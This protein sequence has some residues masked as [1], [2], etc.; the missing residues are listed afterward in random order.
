[1][2]RFLERIGTLDALRREPLDLP[3][4]D[5][6]G[7]V[8]HVRPGALALLRYGHV[9]P[10][11][12]LRIA[13]VARR[14]GREIEEDDYTRTFA[15]VLRAYGQREVEIDRFWDVFIRPALN[16]RSAEAVAHYGIFTVQEAL[17]SDEPGASDLLLPTRPLG[18]I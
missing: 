14:L 8:S 12:R 16:L 3:V 7:R 10:A 9:S 5:E 11:G 1:Y 2:R 6:R 18:E 15:D 17:L 4:I 13:K